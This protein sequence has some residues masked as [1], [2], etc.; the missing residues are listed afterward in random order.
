MKKRTKKTGLQGPYIPTE[1]SCK[2]LDTIV[3][4]SMDF[5]THVA[6]RKIKLQVGS[7][8]QY[9]MKKLGWDSSQLCQSLGAEQI[10]AVAMAIY[11]IEEKQQ[12]VIVGDQTGIGKGRIAAALIKYAVHKGIT[13]IFF[14][15]KPNL[16][17]D[18]Y[19][20]LNSIGA[21]DNV[22]LKIAGE[23]KY[24]QINYKAWEK[25]SEDEQDE[26]GSIDDYEQYQLENP[27]EEIVSY[28]TNPNYENS[29]K[30][31]IWPFIV[32][33]KGSKTDIRDEDGSV[34]YEGLPA[35]ETMSILQSTKLP[36]KYKAIITTYS[37]FNNPKYADKRNFIL[38][39]ARGS[40]IVMDESHN[41]SGNSKT[42]LF[43]TDVLENCKG[44]LFLSATF[45]KR[46][47]NMP[48][49]A[50][51]T[52]LRDANMTK[53]ALIKA[54]DKGGVALQ[55]VISSQLVSEGQMLRR[56]RSFEGIEV[57]Y[58]TLDDKA[59]EH[60]AIS[61]NVTSIMRDI[62][63]FQKK[64]IKPRIKDMEDELIDDYADA[65]LTKGTKD[66]G[67]D[68]TPYFSK[69][70]NVVNQLLF[71]IKAADVADQALIRLR[72]GKKVI[73][74]FSNTMGAFLENIENE[75]GD[76]VKA[77]DVVNVD[78]TT[79]LKKGLDGVMRYTVKRPNSE[80]EV[81][82][83]TVHDLSVQGQEEYFRINNKITQIS[84]GITISPID[85]IIS[86][87]EG[88]GYSVKEV[89]GRK[90]LVNFLN[91]SLN[92]LGRT[93][94]NSNRNITGIVKN[95]EQITT[96][97]AFR[98]FN[99][100]EVD[101]LLINQSGSTGASAQALPTKKITADKV[102]QRWMIML[103]AELNINTEVQKRGRINR[104]G[105]IMLPGYDYVT[106][107]IPAEKR[108][109]MLLQKK[110]KSLDANTTSNQKNSEKVFSFEDFLNKYGD[111]I[112][113]QYLLENVMLNDQ[114]GDPLKIN[115]SN[116]VPDITN[117]AHRVTGRVAI[118]STEEQ[119]K[120]YNEVSKLYADH[121]TFLKD[122]G[123]YNLEVEIVDLQAD[124]IERDVL[125]AGKGGLSVFATDTYIEKCIVNNLK[126]PYKKEEI[127]QILVSMLGDKTADELQKEI[128]TNFLEHENAR[129]LKDQEIVN[130]KFDIQ[131][132]NIETEAKYLKLT[133]D[134]MR[135]EYKNMRTYEIAN[136][137]GT[138]L[139]REN[140]AWKRR[141]NYL[142]PIFKHFKP[143]MV[144]QYPLIGDNTVKGICLGYALD[145]SAANPYAPSAVKLRFAVANGIKS[146]VLSCTGDPRSTLNSI[147]ANGEVYRYEAAQVYENWD[148]IVSE[149]S[150]D[151]IVKYIVTGNLLQGYGA[152]A[153]KLISYTTVD[154]NTK[155]GILM[156]DGYDPTQTGKGSTQVLLPI[157]LEV[158]IKIIENM[159]YNSI[160]ETDQGLTISREWGNFELITN[161][162]SVQRF[163]KILKDKEL[164]Q[165]LR[166]TK[167]GFYK[168]GNKWKASVS[169]TNLV[170]ALQV[171]GQNHGMNINVSRAVFDKYKSLVPQK[172]MNETDEITA[173]AVEMF[174]KDKAA[175]IDK[176]SKIHKL[177]IELKI[178]MQ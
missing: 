18:I 144:I 101:V 158:A 78:F 126:K 46:P 14:T 40:I 65:E 35:K 71:S 85:V 165:Y 88:A 159:S 62:I 11:N 109:M 149:S 58:L 53:E 98:L 129:Y 8:N 135:I 33:G 138:A 9:V 96:N 57:N 81:H 48:I 152:A 117:A 123:E 23:K 100:N 72:Q 163:G 91:N 22:K 110:L 160:I 50:T 136:S 148:T 105:Q 147:I 103:Q 41:A 178:M 83:F 176:L 82:Y 114:I 131:Q 133:E 128:I 132:D 153:G 25:L 80:P 61:D 150:N 177:G 162:V 94:G 107:A 63:S 39:Q 97:E 154:G 157:K 68:S 21:D 137:R 2:S 30:N 121:V 74:A 146:I 90:I 172:N 4:D 120:F 104:T 52:S 3:P 127:R 166:N 174:L 20:D 44:V 122:T 99:N 51:K 31:R 115:D 130:N 66:M 145:K 24:K 56:E 43:M 75:D 141:V 143:G 170:P 5:E 42:G 47:D 70:F 64:F 13:P 119:T 108:L 59:V 77:N 171:L 19:R 28:K 167:D 93:Q 87:L 34:I 27:M 10:E 32:N 118:L 29:G 86:K 134:A 67:I 69:V 89:T 125:V 49:Y 169:N 106:S 17:S 112:V 55:E 76:K 15:E 84:S 173:Q 140:E 79:V 116:E 155:K 95:R 168:T 45:A 156:P 37:Q 12:G 175:K 113:Y 26:Y 73:V 124:T 16:F 1:I 92:G 151:H 164:I 38:S 102:K 6:M 111:K 142:F 161:G 54:I 36:S 60:S 139:E 7:L